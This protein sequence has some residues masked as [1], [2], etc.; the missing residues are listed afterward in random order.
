MH[1]RAA[2]LLTFARSVSAPA[3]FAAA[4][5]LGG[6]GGG[7][8]AAP[9]RPTTSPAASLTAGSGVFTGATATTT[10][11][12]SSP[13]PL[14]T[15]A[16]GTFTLAGLA[17][18]LDA[19]QPPPPG[20]AIGTVGFVTSLG[21]SSIVVQPVPM[22]PKTDAAG[23][24]LPFV[25]NV[26]LVGSFGAPLTIGVDQNTVFVNAAG[27]AG[28]TKGMMILAGG[29]PS[30]TTLQATLI[31][32]VGQSSAKT[33]SV[34]RAPRAPVAKR[35]P[36]SLGVDI[37]GSFSRTIQNL[38]PPLKYT[39]PIVQITGKDAICYNFFGQVA[40]V[41]KTTAALTPQAIL[42]LGV[43]SVNFPFTV[44]YNQQP[45]QF[46]QNGTAF[47][48]PGPVS[49]WLN[50]VP[51][52][53]TDAAPTVDLTAGAVLGASLTISSTCPGSIP[54]VTLA[55][56]TLGYA[57]ESST[58]KAM[59][60]PKQPV[61]L[62]AKSCIGLNEPLNIN[63]FF[64]PASGFPNLIPFGDF[65]AANLVFCDQPTLT[66]D[67]VTANAGNVTGAA[68]SNASASFD[69]SQAGAASV[70]GFGTFTPSAP[71]ISFAIGGLTYQP[72]YVDGYKFVYTLLGVPF[73]VTGTV[74]PFPVTF[75]PLQAADVPVT[76]N[77]TVIGQFCEFAL[78]GMPFLDHSSACAFNG[79]ITYE[80][81]QAGPGTPQC[82]A[83]ANQTSGSV[84][85]TEN[86]YTGTFTVVDN[87]NGGCESSL[88]TTYPVTVSPRSASGPTAAFSFSVGA[89]QI[90]GINNGCSI[91][92]YDSLK[93]YV[94]VDLKF[95]G[96]D[97]Q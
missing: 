64:D 57:I 21:A 15:P 91:K 51:G 33:Q 29:T 95:I 37:N 86:G 68:L 36:R 94:E 89:Q 49:D 25:N 42:S 35:V 7:A 8:G 59:P 1:A 38:A 5:A 75:A 41:G 47:N 82:P 67:F 70:F 84:Q 44:T 9:P 48:G 52:Q 62:D 74:K 60:G 83:E 61:V 19:A 81:C 23:G 78:S 58:T 4:L 11:S 13:V 24:A 97:P 96:E 71:T 66:G 40:G 46:T 53:G 85:V 77:A 39:A 6:C 27:L 87:D 88:V 28:L 76:I 34:V 72:G 3:A 45:P 93:R 10:G 2:T 55:S 16:G 90:H 30:G 50:F 32:P 56:A 22:F 73:D 69:P 43:L 54:P 14:P 79:S 92:I 20:H 63:L 26:A 65:T 31:A 17:A 12:L 18:Q 80:L